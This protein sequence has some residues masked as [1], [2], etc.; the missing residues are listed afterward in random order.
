MFFDAGGVSCPPASI[1]QP[2]LVTGTTMF[3]MVRA[4]GCFGVFIKY[5]ADDNDPFSVIPSSVTCFGARSNMN[6]LPAPFHGPAS[7]SM[8]SNCKLRSVTLSNCPDG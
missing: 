1:F 2:Y 3:R 8:F 6:P 4:T 5:A 7:G